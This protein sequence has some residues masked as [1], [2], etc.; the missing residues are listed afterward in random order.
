MK[1]ILTKPWVMGVWIATCILPLRAQMPGANA[2][3]HP[4]SSSFYIS[5][6]GSYQ[7]LGG[8]FDGENILV[9]PQDIF[10]V[11]KVD[12]ALGIG[13]KVGFKAENV[14]LELSLFRGN[15]D[16]SWAGAQGEAV[17]ALWSLSL[18]YYFFHEQKFQP[19]LQL[20]WSPITS[21][22][23]RDGAALIA[24]MEI[25]DAIYISKL[26]NFNAGAGAAYYL[27]PKVFAYV[28]ALYYR[29]GYG[30]IESEAERVAIELEE[31]IRANEFHLQFG[32]AYSF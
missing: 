14:A 32:V 22:R 24:T 5:L 2:P 20:G 3:A 16:A 25:S 13:G 15:H 27:A 10:V 6:G 26:G 28:T 4:V 29:I 18:Q 8:D 21:L 1:K 9:A 23:V 7:S 12:A 30:S 31:D 19:Y 17:L 11:P